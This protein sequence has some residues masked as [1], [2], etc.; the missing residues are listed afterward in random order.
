MWTTMGFHM[1]SLF[2]VRA[3]ISRKNYEAFVL[4]TAEYSYETEVSAI[5]EKHSWKK[6]LNQKVESA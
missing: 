5:E 1:F 3:K 6:W 2:Y 4:C